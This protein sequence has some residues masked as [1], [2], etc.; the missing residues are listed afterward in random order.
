MK[1]T[2]FDTFIVMKDKDGV[3]GVYETLDNLSRTLA[4]YGIEHSFTLPFKASI[5]KN[6][7]SVANLCYRED[8]AMVVSLIYALYSKVY[9]EANDELIAESLIKITN[10]FTNRF[11]EGGLGI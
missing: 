5:E 11:F 2:L 3:K 4:F 10:S 1:T 6:P 8:D 7:N 9:R